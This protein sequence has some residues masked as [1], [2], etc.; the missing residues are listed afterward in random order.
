MDPFGVL[1]RD[2]FIKGLPSSSSGSCF[3]YELLVGFL[4]TSIHSIEGRL[5]RIRTLSLFVVLVSNNQESRL[6]HVM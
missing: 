6:L 1:L 3:D 2:E 5:H 4:A